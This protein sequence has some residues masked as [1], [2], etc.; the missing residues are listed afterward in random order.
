MLIRNEI[1]DALEYTALRRNREQVIEKDE[2]PGIAL[3]LPDGTWE[4]LNQTLDAAWRRA[5]GVAAKGISALRLLAEGYTH[6]EIGERLG[7]ASANNVSAWVARAR[8]FLKADPDIA[9]LR[10]NAI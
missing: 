6:K 5:S 1:F 9:S 4:K 8:K 10:D 2:L 7:G 3:G